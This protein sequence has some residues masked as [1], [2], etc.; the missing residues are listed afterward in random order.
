MPESKNQKE[1]HDCIQ[2]HHTKK[3]NGG[4]KVSLIYTCTVNAIRTF[5]IFVFA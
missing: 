5:L 2:R 4:D 1:H 3:E